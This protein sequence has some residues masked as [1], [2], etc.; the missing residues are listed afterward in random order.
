MH[1]E[2][3]RAQEVRVRLQGVSGD[4]FKAW[5]GSGHS[6][7]A[8]QSLRWAHAQGRARASRKAYRSK[9]GRDL[10]R[11]RLSRSAASSRTRQGLHLGPKTER[12]AEALTRTAIDHAARHWVRER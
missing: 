5:L 8:R 1:L 7:P 10:R 4:D 2:R 9:A 12:H 3:E 11:Q 6:G